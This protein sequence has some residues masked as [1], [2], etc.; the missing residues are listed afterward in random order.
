MNSNVNLKEELM[1]SNYITGKVRQNKIYAQNLYAALC[2][3]QWQ[4]NQMWP[5]LKDELWSVSWRGAGEMISNIIGYGDYMDWYCSGIGEFPMDD[6]T[7]TVPEGVV[8]DEI[9]NDLFEL[10]WVPVPWPIDN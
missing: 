2:N 9:K 8:T 6:E 10:G 3:M 4:K 1:A 7:S 5:I